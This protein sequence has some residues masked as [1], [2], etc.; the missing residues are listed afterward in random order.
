MGVWNISEDNSYPL[1]E[2]MPS[3]V[4]IVSPADGGSSIS[5]TPTLQWAAGATYPPDSYVVYLGE[6]SGSLE[7][8]SGS[9]EA[10]ELEI[11]SGLSYN[12]TYYWR[13]DSIDQNSTV[14]G[15]EWSFTTSAFAPPLPSGVTL[16]SDGE[17]TGT[18][19]GLNG[20]ITMQR[21]V[22]AANDKVFYE[23]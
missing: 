13:V 6:T 23:T 8:I 11:T 19:S 7:A 16:D 14:E 22:V 17:P 9:I 20:M 12:T 18:A 21:L 2:V 10:T 1:F 3:I 5:V 15:T 4:T